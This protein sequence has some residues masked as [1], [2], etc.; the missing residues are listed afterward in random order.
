MEIGR[1]AIN[2]SFDF[3]R[4]KRIFKYEC[5]HHVVWVRYVIV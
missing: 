1:R 5:M 2:L 4:V 3:M